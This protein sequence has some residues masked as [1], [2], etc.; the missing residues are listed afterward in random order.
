MQRT[1]FSVNSYAVI[2]GVDKNAFEIIFPQIFLIDTHYG[3]GTHGHID[4]HTSHSLCFDTECKIDMKHV[5]SVQKILFS[6]RNS[7]ARQTA[8]YSHH[9]I[10]NQ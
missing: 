5:K 3:R 8:N 9:E 4:P 6:Y 1:K 10:K 7:T 2:L